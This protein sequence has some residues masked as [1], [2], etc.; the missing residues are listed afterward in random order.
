[1]ATGGSKTVIFAAMAGNFAIAVTKFVA[2][3]VTGS[4]A[5]MSEGVHSLVDTGNGLLLL[6]GI[7]QSKK[8][9]DDRHPFGR[10]KE[11]YFWTL[12]VAV[13]VFGLGGGVSVYEG[14]RHVAEPAAQTN[15]GLNYAVL[16]FAVVFEGAAWWVAFREFRKVKGPLGYFAA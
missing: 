2:A 12:I 13:L 16:G 9:S 6:W 15:I 14:V 4:S 11:L 7:R 3:A 10:G 1:M 5:M 8:P